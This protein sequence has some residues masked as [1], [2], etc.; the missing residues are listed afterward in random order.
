M[1]DRLGKEA[2][3]QKQAVQQLARLFGEAA[4]TPDQIFFKDWANDSFTATHSDHEMMMFHS[5]SD[6]D[7]VIEAG[8][9]KRLIWS[10][11]ETASGRERNNGYLEGALEASECAIDLL[12]DKIPSE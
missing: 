12:S 11:T 9:D 1:K 10:G 2:E 3:L 6:M 8:W 5:Y 4:A 7:T